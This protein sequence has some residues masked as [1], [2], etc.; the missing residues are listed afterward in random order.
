MSTA[1][2]EFHA[3]AFGYDS[4]GALLVS[5]ELRFLGKLTRTRREV[6]SGGEWRI[7]S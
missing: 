5:H 3:V 7:T 4:A 6:S 2:V 1:S